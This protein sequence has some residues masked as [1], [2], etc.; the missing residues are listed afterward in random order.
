MSFEKAIC[1]LI[2]QKFSNTHTH[3]RVYFELHSKQ[4]K[5]PNIQYIFPK[6]HIWVTFFESLVQGNHIDPLQHDRVV[7]LLLS[8]IYNLAFRFYCR[9]YYIF[10]YKNIEISNW[11]STGSFSPTGQ[12]SYFWKFLQKLSKQKSK[13]QSHPAQNPVS[14]SNDICHMMR[15]WLNVMGVTRHFLIGFNYCL[16]RQN[17]Y[18]T[19]SM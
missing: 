4:S 3:T 15:E 12:H 7:P 6:N 10:E 8:T 14:H 11:Y 2:P 17:P 5:V 1:N 18:M 13:L 9:R 16:K 19:S